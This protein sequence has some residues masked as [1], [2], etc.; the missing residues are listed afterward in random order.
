MG[1]KR[2]KRRDPAAL[3]QR[4]L[5][6]AQLF[7]AGV[8]QAEVARRLG[9]KPSSANRW[10]QAWQQ[11][12]EAA[13]ARRGPPGPKPR[14]SAE[15]L[16]QLE[17][18]LLAGPLAAGYS[19]DLWTL[20]RVVKLVRDRFGVKYHQSGVWLLLHR[21]DWSCQKPAKQAKERDEAASNRWLRER[22]PAI[23]RGRH[24]AEP[25]SCS[26]TK[27]ASPNDPASAAP[28]HPGAKPRS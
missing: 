8:S 19:T 22:W 18:L 1:T 17:L 4:R 20:E 14:L 28:G 6:A 25:R 26:G 9:V 27:Q 10:H 2:S 21:L 15:Q 12:G 13:L 7:A 3:E 5:E 23:K 16:Q 24:A 11:A